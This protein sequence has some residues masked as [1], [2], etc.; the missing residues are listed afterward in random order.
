MYAASI[1]SEGRDGTPFTPPHPPPV[2]TPIAARF[3]NDDRGEE[4]YWLTRAADAGYWKGAGSLSLSYS[5]PK[6][7]PPDYAL[8]EHYGAIAAQAGSVGAASGIGVG[9]NEGIYHSLPLCQGFYNYIFLQR[10]LRYDGE[11]TPDAIF[12]YVLQM[13]K[14]ADGAACLKRE[15][16]DAGIAESKR[17]YDAWKAKYDEQER[18]KKE[19][20][21]KARARI[22]EVK[23]AYDK[24]VAANKKKE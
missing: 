10:R 6:S 8:A 1:T 18:Q 15:T 4:R 22:P 14:H 23:A 3:M 17:L 7:G 11:L 2:V 19:L 9:Y 24:A 5:H 12:A 21:D 16:I 20:Y 13:K